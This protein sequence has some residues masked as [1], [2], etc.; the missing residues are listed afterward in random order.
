MELPTLRYG[1]GLKPAQPVDEVLVVQQKLGL[2]PADGRFG[3]D[4]RTAV[5]AFQ[6]RRGLED[7]G[8]VGPLTWTALFDVRA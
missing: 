4:T 5:K 8:V 1:M 3:K 7:D 6:K 2:V